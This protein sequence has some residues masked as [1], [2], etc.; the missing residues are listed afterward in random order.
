MSL[1]GS[2]NILTGVSKNHIM[3]KRSGDHF[4]GF[5]T[6]ISTF[7]IKNSSDLLIIGGGGGAY[8]PSCYG[9]DY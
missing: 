5:I 9:P 2:Q 7:A 4:C 6:K 8:P 3:R 1:C